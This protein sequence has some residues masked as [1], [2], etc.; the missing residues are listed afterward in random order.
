MTGIG[1]C[2]QAQLH[3]LPSEHSWQ[4][5]LHTAHWRSDGR[6]LP[7]LIDRLLYNLTHPVSGPILW[8]EETN[9][10]TTNLEDA[11]GMVK[12]V[13]PADQA[14]VKQMATQ[15]LK[16]SP[17]LTIPCI[18]DADAV[19]KFPWRSL[20]AFS[21]SKT[22]ALVRACKAL[23]VTVTAAVH[24]AIAK[25]NIA[26]ATTCSEKL[27]YRSSIRRDLRARFP[28]QYRSPIS[29]ATG[30]FT[31]A[32][33]FS[34]PVEKDGTW[35]KFAK[36]LTDEYR[37][38]YNDELFRLHRVY[39]R[40]LIEGMIQSA[41]KGGQTAAR[42]ADVDTSS[43]GLIE[44]MVRRDYCGREEALGEVKLAQ[45][46]MQVLEVTV[47]VNSCSRQA[48]VFVYTFR[49]CLNLYMTYNEAYHT[50]EDMESFLEEVRRTLDVALEITKD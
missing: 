4:I 34:L 28:E 7:H 26:R 47:S 36:R 24:A 2:R 32:T 27:D 40:Q 14:R 46:Q 49:D 16:G 9:R 44:N 10:L 13:S 1:L 30:L 41:A 11:A 25:T 35:F 43:I 22:A 45:V 6:G 17:A 19:T 15:L 21:A 12:E 20:L 48:A 38:S 18:E 39:Y 29:L 5:V 50:R 8:G 31:T 37:G 42:A 3:V 23:D 33:I